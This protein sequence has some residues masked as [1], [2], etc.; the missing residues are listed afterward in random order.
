[1]NK[2]NKVNIMTQ[3]ENKYS[4]GQKVYENIDQYFYLK[5]TQSNNLLR[6][7][8]HLNRYR[9]SNSLVKS[10]YTNRAK[11]I[12]LGC[13]S[14]DWNQ[15]KLDVFGVDLNQNFL[16][17]AKQ[18]KRLSDY[19]VTGAGETG[20]PAGSF[21]IATAFEFLEHVNDYEKIITEAN[22]LLK[23]GG[24]FII[25]VPYDVLFSLWRPLFFAQVLFRGY[26]LNEEY[27]KIR[28]G[29]VNHFSPRKLCRV[30]I[31]NGFSVDLL[32]VMRGFTI[33]LCAVKKP[34]SDTHEDSYE[35]TTIILPTLNE[36]KNIHPI[37]SLLSSR[38]RRCSIIVS[39]D[40]SKDDTKNLCLNFNYD[41]LVFLDR[42]KKKIHGL[43]VSV[44]DAIDLVRTKY[45]I[46]MD[47][48]GQ[49]QTKKIEEIINILRLG[50][51]I[52][53]A[54]RAQVQQKWG[55][56]RMALS[57]LGT[58]IGKISLSMRGKK[59]INYDI[60]GGFFGCRTRFWKI[61][62]ALTFKE[63]HFRLRG[64]KILFDFL[65]CLPRRVVIEEVYYK[66]GIRKANV[67]KI[68]WRVNFEYL[69]ACFLK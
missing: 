57:Y 2:E 31:K 10:K 11:I 52:V 45:F 41:K 56:F 7:W 59:Y 65:K 46:V 14:C 15:E 26:V 61:S 12:D 60:L 47:A 50:S 44:L 34:V 29:H 69:K 58:I 35:D 54:S 27:Y 49:H 21:N 42:T 24:F 6:R 62:L 17:L 9:I 8:F 1:M 22:R 13:G 18:N 39:D 3:N 5:Q 36:D 40:G 67:S 30:L 25:S 51:R 64:F 48:D 37:L 23:E 4:D 68:N 28:C 20:L 55:I 63:R 33:F 43:T 16:K 66:F 19:K 38:Y 32:F 53:I